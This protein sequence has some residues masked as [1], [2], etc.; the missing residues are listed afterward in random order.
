MEEYCT[1]DFAAI[2]IEIETIVRNHRKNMKMTHS[3]SFEYAWVQMVIVIQCL[4]EFQL[5]QINGESEYLHVVALK[6][7]FQY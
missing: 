5:N 1:T 2:L 3:V 4:G 6:R 7:L